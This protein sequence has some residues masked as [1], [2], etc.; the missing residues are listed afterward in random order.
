VKKALQTKH[1]FIDTQAFVA[2]HFE[3][4]SRSFQSLISLAR[5]KR[6]SIHLTTITVEEVKSNICEAVE[7]ARSGFLS[8][9]SKHDTQ[10]LKNISS[11]LGEVFK[12]QFDSGKITE[13][14][15]LQLDHFLTRALIHIIPIEGASITNV[16]QDYF[17]RKPPF[18]DKKKAEFPDAFVLSA[19]RQW[20]SE[21][22]EKIYV[23]SGDLDMVSACGSSNFLISLAKINEFLDLVSAENEL[24]SFANKL[25]ED[26]KESIIESI[27]EKFPDIRIWLD[28]PEGEV[29]SVDVKSVFIVKRYLIDLE[30]YRAIFELRV[31]V[32][33]SADIEYAD[34]V[35]EEVVVHE[36]EERIDRSNRISVE[37]SLVFDTQDESAG[38][39]EDVII[40][41]NDI[42]LS[43]RPT[44]E[45]LK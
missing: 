6:I 40:K 14:V 31:H 24:Y 34:H 13:E 15:Y 41:D 22:G 27:K 4:V 1:V 32:D 23:V 43:S 35:I 19:I 37:V 20:C 29:L 3:F 38:Q 33:Y 42:V 8:F 11:I 16:F 26:H 36:T 9:T 44:D 39:I 25:F 45:Q 7:K 21:T 30:E 12:F 10:I 18:S 28:E 2:N 17:S 5:S